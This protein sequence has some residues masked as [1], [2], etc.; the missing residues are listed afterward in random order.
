MEPKDK[1]PYETPTIMVVEA[2]TEGIICASDL[3]GT[4]NGYSGWN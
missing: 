1:E 2:K 3:E 4:G